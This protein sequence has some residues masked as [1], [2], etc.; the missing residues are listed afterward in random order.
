[1]PIRPRVSMVFLWINHISSR[2]IIRLRS[3]K[4]RGISF[5]H[6]AN[7][8]EGRLARRDVKKDPTL[9]MEL[10][11]KRTARATANPA[12]RTSKAPPNTDHPGIRNLS[13][14][15]INGP[16]LQLGYGE[17]SSIARET[18]WILNWYSG[19]CNLVCAMMGKIR[20]SGLWVDLWSN[21]DIQDTKLPISSTA[22]VLKVEFH[23]LLRF[24]ILQFRSNWTRTR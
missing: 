20:C 18:V 17:T 11:P 1:M 15:Q 2:R 19:A 7:G 12:E 23:P 22:D 3:T 6:V 4:A 10:N 14:W 9:N 5:E 21:H 13:C 8:G 24:S 16:F